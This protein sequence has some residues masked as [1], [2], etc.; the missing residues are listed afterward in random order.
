MKIQSQPHIKPRRDPQNLSCSSSPK[1][2][3]SPVTSAY[4]GN[5]Q[6]EIWQ[7]ETSVILQAIRKQLAGHVPCPKI[8]KGEQVTAVSFPFSDMYYVLSNRYRVFTE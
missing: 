7:P 1:S 4:F 3:T 5:R 8:S 6:C 2:T